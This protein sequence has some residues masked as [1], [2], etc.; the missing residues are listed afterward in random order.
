MICPISKIKTL[1][2]AGTLIVMLNTLNTTENQAQANPRDTESPLAWIHREKIRMGWSPERYEQ[3]HRMADAG[4]NA[5]M[6][7]H[8]L[9]VVLEYDP[10]QAET[11]QSPNDA[12]IIEMIRD[13]SKLSK[14]LGMRYFHCLNLAAERQTYEV[15]FHNNPARENDGRLPSPVDYVY[16]KRTILD[17][18]SRV[19][20]L[21]E[22]Q[23]TYALDAI[24]LD[25]EM[26]ALGDALPGHADYGKFAF[27]LYLQETKQ[28]VSSSE[29]TT[30]DLRR[31]WLIAKD[32]QESYEQW[33]F[34]VI[35]G[36]GRELRELVH[37]R[38]P[39]LLLGYIIYEDK[40]WFHA[41][42]A[43]LSTPEMPVFIGP[44]TT[45]SG[46]MDDRMIAYLA[47]IREQV[48]VPTIL[49]PGIMMMMDNGRVPH[50]FLEVVPGNVYQ[51]CQYSEGYWVYAIYTFGD[52]DE[53]QSAF[54][55][56]LKIVD[57]ALDEQAR[58]GKV[59]DLPASPLPIKTPLGFNEML[60][61]ARDWKPL[62]SPVT[63]ATPS[64]ITAK[65]RGSYA[66]VLWPQANERERATI[67]LSGIQFG[68]YLDVCEAMLF[69]ENNQLIWKDLVPFNRTTG[70]KVPENDS[71]VIGAIISSGMNAYAI[72]DTTCPMMILP[73][74]YLEVNA[75]QGRAGRFYF[76]VPAGKDQFQ[77]ALANTQGEPA[78]YTVY[79]S[80]GK[81]VTTAEAVNRNQTIDVS[82]AGSSGPG[83][84]SIE[85]HHVLDDAAFKLV[86]L[87]NRFALRPEYIMVD[88]YESAQ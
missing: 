56:A 21:L 53:E 48:K 40:M 2:V 62:A 79:D 75:Q 73:E 46:V 50:E 18:V 61:D 33:Q 3:Y 7:R 57:D 86:D 80:M 59:V 84:W 35:A 5:V 1:V 36:F 51:R 25:P 12:K 30:P 68:V 82:V 13:G 4:M 47:G 23:E 31:D 28:A 83:V 22:D 63:Q 10:A 78:D 76:Y 49:V 9:D 32:L 11:P 87:P 70:L 29:L 27:E 52:T 64:D 54:F 71:K 44:E 14:D 65:L 34:D 81:P 15:G 67:I 85:V 42:A 19:L 43:G 39:E 55:N 72:L 66:M 88:S 37:A 26:Y 60:V 8:E 58:T 77:V 20:D 45:Y 16:W 6:P 17:R 69:D 74:N 38:R 41:M 24:I